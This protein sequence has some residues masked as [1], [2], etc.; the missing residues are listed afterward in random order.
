MNFCESFY[1]AT[2]GRTHHSFI[3]EIIKLLRSDDWMIIVKVLKILSDYSLRRGGKHLQKELI[4]DPLKN[5]ALAWY[6]K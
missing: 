2:R 3:E 1:Q 5:L 6:L 4:K